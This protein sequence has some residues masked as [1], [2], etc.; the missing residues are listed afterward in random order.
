MAEMNGKRLKWACKF[1]VCFGLI[2]SEETQGV[3]SS[4]LSFYSHALAFPVSEC[5]LG[6]S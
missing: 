4:F 6:V 2:L 5:V 3:T 1:R